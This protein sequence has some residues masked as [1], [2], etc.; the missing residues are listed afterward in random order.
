MRCKRMWTGRLACGVAVGLL[1]LAP[2]V[3]NAQ[4]DTTTPGA[5]S[6][7]GTGTDTGTGTGTGMGTGTGTGMG[8][9]MSSQPMQVTGTVLRYYTDRSGF[10][11]AM[12]IQTAEGVQMVHFAPGMGQR[13]FTNF[14]VGGQQVSV[15][16]M[17][18]TRL[19][20][21]HWT[22][23]GV[24]ATQPAA[25][26]M[27]PYLVSDV[28]LLEAEPQTLIG[29]KMVDVAGDLRGVVTD[30][31]GEVL[32]LVLENVKVDGAM[33]GGAMGAGTMG[34]GTAGGTMGTDTT[35]G[36]TMAGG[37]TGGATMGGDT[38][39]G[40]M[41][42]GATG[43][44]LDTILVRVP[45]EMRHHATGWIGS[46][47]VSP[48]FRG[49]RVE[50][51]GYPEAPRFG[52]ISRHGQRLVARALVINGR[53][54]GALGIPRMVVKRNRTLLGWNIPV[55]GG[56][57]SP[58]EERAG[59]AG[60]T[61]YGPNTPAP[62]TMNPSETGAGTTGTDTTGGGTMGT[63]TDTGTTGDTT[64]TT[65]TDAGTAGGTE[66]GTERRRPTWG[67]RY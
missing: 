31:Q 56:A 59:R 28:E 30:D 15:W 18:H 46:E 49:A 58:E 44:E 4:G 14:P 57:M 24:G 39:G 23:V 36:G 43:A 32:G 29:A 40:T 11:T 26:F 35:T 41:M 45:R 60:Y 62:T 17:P 37:T 10:V 50:A 61:V 5:G 66:G 38:T 1:A 34:G 33:M 25:G 67:D 48:L 6:G 65:G 47:R 42:G 51:T 52:V 7:A 8:M 55:G 13:M 21:G 64:G 12:D 22:L 19:G 9:T 2:V 27:T 20:A 63:G 53:A 54:V 16:V 3:A